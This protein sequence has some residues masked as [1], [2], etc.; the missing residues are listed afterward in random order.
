M[1]KLLPAAGALLLNFFA[2]GAQA[3]G[4]DHAGPASHTL[5]FIENKG[6]WDSRARYAAPLPGGRLFAEA[7]GLTFSLLANGGPAQMGHQPP[8][9]NRAAD[10]LLRG[11][12]L[13]LRFDGAA[14][15]TITAETPTAEHRNYFLGD[16]AKHW[17]QDV[18]SFR[19]LHYA[20]LWPGVSAR[21][22]ES[23]DQHLE[24]DFVLAPGARPEAIAL[25]HDGADGLQ[26]DAAGNLLVRTNVGTITERAPLAWQTDAAGRRTAVACRY[27]L[28]GK[29]AHFALGKYDA[30][31]PLTIDPVVVFAAYT[32]ST[33]DNWGFTA[34]YDAQGNLYS[35]GIA[36]ALGY[37]ASPGAFRTTF[38]GLIDIAII[39]YNTSAN[40]PAARVWATY[41]GGVSADFPA[42]LVVNSLGELLVLGTTSSNNYP[43]TTGALQRNFAG[44]ISTDPYGYGAGYDLPNGS[45]LVIT[46]LNAAGSALVSSTYLGGSGNDGVLPLNP[47]TANQL[48]H[49]YGDP[50]RGDIL[51]DAADNVYV[52]SHTSSTLFPLT[53]ATFNNLYRGGA[54]DGLVFKL[55]PGLT[56][57]TWGGFLGGAASDAAY[58]IQVAPVSGDVYVAGGTLSANFP[59]TAGSLRTTPFGDVDGFAAR[60]AATGTS[61]VRATYLGTTSYDQGYFLQLGTDGGVYVLGQT[62]GA[63]PTTLGLYTTPNGRQ[64]IHKLDANLGA[65]QLATV[66]GSGRNTIDI[67]PTAFLVDR[68]DRV[69]VCGWGGALNNGGGFE[70]Y[71]ALNGT[72]AGLPITPGAVQPATDDNDFYLVQ[73]SAG[74][75]SLAYATYYGA[76]GGSGDHVD[77]GTARFDPRGVV[78]QAVCSCGQGSGFPIPPGANT[79]STV[80][81]SNNCNNA[82]FVFNF[83]PSIANAGNDQTVCATAGPQ[84]L[85]GSPGGG[86]W[87]GPGVTGSVATGFVFTPSVALVGVQVL[88][89]T[90]LS[91][92]LCTTTGTRRVTVLPPPQ[93][94]FTPLSQPVYCLPAPGAPALP[95]VRLSATPAGGTFSGPG[96]SG[97]ASAGYFFSPNIAA[98]NYQLVY[99]VNVNGC[100]AQA[101]QPV[102]VTNVLTAILPA[103][104][105]ICP[106]SRQPF[107][108]RGSPAGGVFSGV[109][110]TGSAATGFVF[111]PPANFPTPITLTYT[112]SNGG[113]TGTG[114]RRISVAPAPLLLAFWDPVACP[115]TRLTPLTVRFTLASS[116]SLSPPP[117]LLWDF[118]D[119]SQST[120][121]SPTHTYA[122]PGSYQPRVRL[123][124]N[125]NRCEIAA[126][127]PVVEVK[128]R[129][130]PNIITPNGDA[131]NQTFKLGPD[132]PPRLQVFSR[133]GRQ[134][135]DS[136]A[137][138][139]E[140]S[141]AGQPDGV[142]YYL[143]TY[144][145]GHRVK[146]WVEVVR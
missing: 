53:G 140:W 62:A 15:A 142:Y 36:F 40:G 38:A 33:A 26:L 4:S 64:F 29:V 97:N 50:F 120:E 86:L 100:V 105:V 78:Y 110:V 118:G 16:D 71:L 83:E 141:A 124:Y 98:G 37:P 129:K 127:A 17:A 144:P 21:V 65:T 20:G 46:R 94:N 132:C 135:F 63:Y 119:G 2:N 134:V 111:T 42:S 108:L 89:Y 143:I 99:T 27:V 22:Y 123:G 11:H 52:A 76:S 3:Q 48:A 87:S 19:E 103:D 56:A 138:H 67:D 126:A 9:K 66:F 80:N 90:V 112:V 47:G 39:K 101:S 104:T 84:A 5:E 6:Q 23:A 95:S 107:A 116:S 18:R 12:A 113:C 69:Y 13:M 24:Y 77:G 146:G 137:Y 81:P 130:I 30:R 121:L 1:K 34:T 44:G 139:D 57:M 114:T 43:V 88:T 72:T 8:Q 92:G 68:C 106:G 96:V 60:I 93:V 45:D 7:D 74:L 91:T 61:I 131:L 28:A 133:W 85:V 102:T 35:G 58:S 14:P 59:T 51:V 128:E 117:A 70:P 136:P 75:G 122:A 82:A 25:R 54:T 10:S 125:S 115:E 55:N 32:G 49:N 145:D 79:Y 41:L 31:R 73:F 109:G